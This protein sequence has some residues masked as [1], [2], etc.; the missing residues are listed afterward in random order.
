MENKPKTQQEIEQEILE[1]N[2]QFS[3]FLHAKGITARFKLALNN[4][5]E[6]A[7]KQHSADVAEFEEIKVQSAEDNKEFAEFLRSKGIKTKYKLVIENI[8]NS[9]KAA[10]ANTASQIAKVQAK[11]Q[12]AVAHANAI[13]KK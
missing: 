12:A 6:S 5:S 1:L 11:T 7:K 8:K 4:M 3:A 13:S 2:E 9:A 10:P